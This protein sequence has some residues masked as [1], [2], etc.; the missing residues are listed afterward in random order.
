MTTINDRENIATI[1]KLL[2]ENDNFVLHCDYVISSYIH[3]CANNKEVLPIIT[4]DNRIFTKLAIK[5]L[6]Y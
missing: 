5:F 6:G 3:Y 4:I 1:T 2:M